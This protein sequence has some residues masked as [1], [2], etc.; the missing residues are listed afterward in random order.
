MEAKNPWTYFIII[1]VLARDSLACF[2]K[3]PEKSRVF[4]K[5]MMYRNVQEHGDSRQKKIIMKTANNMN[6]NQRNIFL[7][8]RLKLDALQD[9]NLF[10]TLALRLILIDLI[11]GQVL[12]NFI[13]WF[14]IPA[15]F[16]KF[17]GIF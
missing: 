17:R 4:Y 11:E 14:L 7:S 13:E 10:E 3:S 5:Y 9:F 15:Q 1:V 12:K 6:E 16:N 2:G 8:C